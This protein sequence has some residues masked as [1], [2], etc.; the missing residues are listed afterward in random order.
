MKVEV[1]SLISLY[2]NLSMMKMQLER[3]RCCMLLSRCP[4]TISANIIVH[5]NKLQE[6]VKS[7]IKDEKSVLKPE[8]ILQKNN[9]DSKC[10][11]QN[12][13]NHSNCSA[14]LSDQ[15]SL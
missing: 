11:I 15:V 14:G 2:G 10:C 4:C 9:Q 12:I 6:Y 3:D 13:I 7:I 8:T 5:C 1:W